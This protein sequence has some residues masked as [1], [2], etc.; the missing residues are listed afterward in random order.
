[1]SNVKQN[2]TQIDNQEFPGRLGLTP[3]MLEQNPLQTYRSSAWDL[4]GQLSF[5]HKKDEAWRWVDLSELNFAELQQANG[6]ARIDALSSDQRESLTKNEKDYSGSLIISPAGVVRQVDANLEQAG[7]IFT[8][9]KTA[10][11]DYSE[12]V[13]YLER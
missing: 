3:E 12:L 2:A 11:T 5:P 4:A 10:Q 1:M 9:F 6:N 8:D 7:V 13:S